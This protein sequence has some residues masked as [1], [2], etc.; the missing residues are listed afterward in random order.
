VVILEP[1]EVRKQEEDVLVAVHDVGEARQGRLERGASRSACRPRS[2]A[3]LIQAHGISRGV[4][5][6]A[7]QLSTA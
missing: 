2:L 4:E 6:L 7:E 1:W 3:L 5:T